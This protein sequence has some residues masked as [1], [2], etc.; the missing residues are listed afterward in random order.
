[1]KPVSFPE[2]NMIFAEGQAE[3]LPLPAHRTPDGTVV[4]CWRMTW[5]ERLKALFNGKVW[6]MTLTFNQPL[7][8]QL[9][10]I[11]APFKQDASA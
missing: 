4:T 11:D 10:S 7:Q 8:P 5:R 3:Y 1:M 9:P 2:Q 6:F